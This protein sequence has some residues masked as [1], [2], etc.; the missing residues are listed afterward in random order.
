MDL[1][2]GMHVAARSGE[3]VGR[4]RHDVLAR[5]SLVPQRFEIEPHVQPRVKLRGR[6]RSRRL[7]HLLGR[8]RAAKHLVDLPHRHARVWT[9]GEERRPRRGGGLGARN[10]EKMPRGILDVGGVDGS[11]QLELRAAIGVPSDV[12]QA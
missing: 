8:Q 9:D 2:D 11:V 4:R 1:R 6:L 7:Q 10:A 12:V 3:P 5:L